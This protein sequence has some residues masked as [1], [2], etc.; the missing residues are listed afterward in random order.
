MKS[1]SKSHVAEYEPS[2]LNQNTCIFV[3]SDEIFQVGVVHGKILV[4]DCD[5]RF[6]D[7]QIS[8]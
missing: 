6:G 1:K 7:N 2:K 8:I 4:R 5:L 3:M